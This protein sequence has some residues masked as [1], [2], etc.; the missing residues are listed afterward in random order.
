M[1]PSVTVEI[2]VVTDA[3]I[4]FNCSVVL[5]VGV[6]G[7]PENWQGTMQITVSDPDGSILAVTETIT[8]GSELNLLF[9][10]RLGGVHGLNYTDSGLPVIT[11]STDGFSFSVV[12]VP[13]ALKL[14][15]GLA[16]LL[17][18]SG[19]IGVIGFLVR[20]KVGAMIDNL[21]NEWEST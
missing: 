13:F 6:H 1:L 17:G 5:G 12:D 11:N 14:D 16:P 19:I 7:V 8:S 9:V 2:I 18:G 15:I 3:Y 20:K 4:G 10:P 21:P